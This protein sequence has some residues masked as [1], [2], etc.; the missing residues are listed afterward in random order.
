MDEEKNTSA[1]CYCATVACRIELSH[2]RSIRRMCILSNKQTLVCVAAAS[3]QFG[4]ENFFVCLI[5]R[6]L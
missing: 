3:N 6:V 4:K 1:V 5:Y 2:F